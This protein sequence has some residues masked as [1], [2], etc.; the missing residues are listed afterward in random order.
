LDRKAGKARSFA[1]AGILDGG[2]IAAAG[3]PPV[4]AETSRSSKEAPRMS[5]EEQASMAAWQK[6]MTPGEHHKALE[7]LVG[8]FDAR[9]RMW[10]Q[11]GTPP[12]ESAGV[13]ENRFI[14]GGRYLQQSYKGMAMGM[15]FEGIGY[16]GYDNVQK[17][18]VGTWMDS[19]GT[20]IM[21]GLGTGSPTP[22][23]MT[24]KNDYFDPMT[25]KPCSS[26]SVI[27]V[28]DTNHHKYEMYGPAPDGKEFKMMEIEY[29]RR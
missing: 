26:R 13:S 2:V 1:A 25:G 28:A 15:P 10:M 11:P 22:K 23:E 14:L 7:P 29:T 8:T 17:K 5:A 21:I 16:T 20:G 12:Q 24:M 4:A 9:F 27:S 3:A 19:F 6:A 18:Y